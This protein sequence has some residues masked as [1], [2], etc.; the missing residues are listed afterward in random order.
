[1]V[2]VQTRGTLYRNRRYF[3]HLPRDFRLGMSMKRWAFLI[4]AVYLFIL[5]VA[6]SAAL[7]LAFG[8]EPLQA[9]GW[10]EL[11][12]A[13]S[14]LILM[15]LGEGLLLLV[16]VGTGER[17]PKARRKLWVPLVTSAFFLMLLTACGA[18]CVFLAIYGDKE[19]PLEGLD[20][21]TGV[22]PILLAITGGL[23]LFWGMLFW[24]FKQ[25]TDPDAYTG[26]LMRWLL[27]GSV[28]E[29]LVAVPSHIIVRQRND[30]CAP[31]G[32]FFGIVTGL[33]VMFMA[34]GPG[35]L[36]LYVKRMRR[37]R[38]DVGPVCATCGYDMRATPERCPECGT[39]VAGLRAAGGK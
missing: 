31:A 3:R 6:G 33:A 8:L 12:L 37:L 29:L 11:P 19:G 2:F 23:W 4:V 18:M 36:L 5:V 28:L 21:A 17:R 14:W 10:I 35:V 22:V 7:M 20:F 15:L 34:F 9:L 16:P 13:W 24:W 32:T 25:Q 38:G 26:R 30:C 27:A 1:M 39:A